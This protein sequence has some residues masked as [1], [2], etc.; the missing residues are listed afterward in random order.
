MAIKHQSQLALDERVIEDKDVEAALERR[1]TAHD[2][3]S[4]VRKDFQ[5]AHDKALAEIQKLELPEGGGSPGR[6]IPR[7][8]FEPAGT[9]R[10][11]R[12]EGLVTYPDLGR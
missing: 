3:L 4:E 8:P 7:R 10:E 1:E 6:S 11:L 9:Q 12:D 2:E 5:A